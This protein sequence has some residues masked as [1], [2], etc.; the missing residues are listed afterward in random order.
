MDLLEH[1]RPLWERIN[2]IFFLLI[3]FSAA[4]IIA[5]YTWFNNLRGLVENI[6]PLLYLFSGIF[7]FL[8]TYYNHIEDTRRSPIRGS[9]HI[10]EM[11]LSLAVS[12][13]GIYLI[14]R[15]LTG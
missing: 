5:V 12:L 11:I 15:Q 10:F 1:Y 3:T 7:G 4:F 8:L 13:V 14:I 9:I 2:K 6:L